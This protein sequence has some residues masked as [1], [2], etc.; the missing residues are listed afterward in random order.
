M[1][2]RKVVSKSG[3]KKY[4]YVKLIEN[5]REE[6]KVKQRVVANLGN[7][8]DISPEKAKKLIRGLARACGIS[9]HEVIARDGLDSDKFHNTKPVKFIA[10]AAEQR[11]KSLGGDE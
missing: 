6:G 4:V 7:V 11:D 8:E 9:L 5:Y 1:F 2:F 3:S 10:R